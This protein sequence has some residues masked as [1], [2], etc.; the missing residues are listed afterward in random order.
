[1]KSH[2][3]LMDPMPSINKVFSYVTQ[4]ECQIIGSNLFNETKVKINGVN[5]Q[6]SC[7]L[8]GKIGHLEASSYRKNGFPQNYDGKGFKNTSRKVCIHYGRNGY[9][10]DICY[11]KPS[12][13]PGHKFSNKKVNSI[14]YIDAQQEG[15]QDSSNGEQDVCLVVATIS[16]SHEFNVE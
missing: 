6:L 16:S 1:M 14:K 4:Q 10:I 3:L 2:V 11:I 9:T 15:N 7:T 13:P 8:C 5:N 12:F